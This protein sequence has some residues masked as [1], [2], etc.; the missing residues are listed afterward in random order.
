M[1]NLLLC[2]SIIT[3]IALSGKLSDNFSKVIETEDNPVAISQKLSNLVEEELY[4]D[5]KSK[6]A[7]SDSLKKLLAFV[8]GD[9]TQIGLLKKD[10]PEKNISAVLDNLADEYEKYTDVNN[11]PNLDEYNEKL[12]YFTLQDIISAYLSKSSANYFNLDF[13]KSIGSI[14]KR[15]EL[16]I[17]KLKTSKK[18]DIVEDKTTTETITTVT[19]VYAKKLNDYKNY[20]N[21]P[22]QKIMG[23]VQELIAKNDH[24]EFNVNNGPRSTDRI[25][26]LINAIPKIR[27]HNKEPFGEDNW[28]DYIENL[29]GELDNKRNSDDL[30]DA[31]NDWNTDLIKKLL[32]LLPPQRALDIIRRKMEKLIDS[33]INTSYNNSLKDRFTTEKIDLSD[34]KDKKNILRIADLIGGGSNFEFDN[35]QIGN[36]I[37]NYD[38]LFS[39]DPSAYNSKP[40]TDNVF[41]TFD[42]EGLRNSPEFVNL[43]DKTYNARLDDDDLNGDNNGAVINR[44]LDD[45]PK[46][47]GNLTYKLINLKKNL[48]DGGKDE[49]VVI[50]ANEPQI[51]EFIGN[52]G[53]SFVENN[54]V[55]ILLMYMYIYDDPEQTVPIDLDVPQIINKI[56]GKGF[57][58]KKLKDMWG[59]QPKI[60]QKPEI[61]EIDEHIDEELVDT[62]IP[63]KTLI[64]EEP[65]N[66]NDVEQQQNI[67]L[68]DPQKQDQ[69]SQLLN[70]VQE[71]EEDI[72]NEGPKSHNQSSQI[73][74][75]EEVED[76]VLEEEE[77]TFQEEPQINRQPSQLTNT[78]EDE[79]EEMNTPIKEL[80]DIDETSIKQDLQD[81]VQEDSSV[82]LPP[83]VEVQSGKNL[84]IKRLGSIDPE[85]R[86]KLEEMKDFKSF[87]IETKYLNMET[88]P[89]TD[90]EVTIVYIDR[91]ES[92]CYG[93]N[94]EFK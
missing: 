15:V 86:K 81:P 9:K 38:T 60:E 2:L 12:K 4:I 94:G 85:N 43:V 50:D 34:P 20:V 83:G 5:L 41:N 26:Y 69:P 19:E 74:E 57:N 36:L 21:D 87:T 76:E 70:E 68:E 66:I 61:I 89:D 32:G 16:F 54:D 80:Q 90:V 28:F 1:I 23:G 58:S 48:V 77:D 30:G 44:L 29:I 91:Y 49:D 6:E 72:K 75:D 39:F 82:L 62:N 42:E 79:E 14:V 63:K 47:D 17:D 33:P 71:D 37:D 13:V 73:I 53:S 18:K 45:E 46:T 64:D 10:Y 31:Y 22:I 92:N 40:L 56:N 67:L 78:L 93:K 11:I 24:P 25:I 55:P 65:F 88:D 27:P 8:K 59:I 52:N 35:D 51:Q 84:V 3:N 7:G